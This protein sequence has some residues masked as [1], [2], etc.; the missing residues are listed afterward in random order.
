MELTNEQL[1][2]RLQAVRQ[3]PPE[4]VPADDIQLELLEDER[5]KCRSLHQFMQR[6]WHVVEPGKPFIDGWHVGAICEH[7]E[8]VTVGQIRRLVINV[9]PRSSKSSAT[10]VF[11]PG[12]VWT[13]TPSLQWLCVSHSERLATDHTRKM[14]YLVK[15]EWYQERWPLGFATDQM[16]KSFF[17]NDLNGHRI[18]AGMTGHITGLGGDILLLDDPHDRDEAFSETKR[19]RARLEYREKLSTRLNNPETGA[20]VA[21]GQRLHMEDLFQYLIEI[22]FTLLC[23]PMR[24]EE[25][26]PFISTSGWVDPRKQDGELMCPDRFPDSYV[27]EMETKVL[28]K[29]GYAGQYQQR[30]SPR[31]GG[32]FQR[33]WF[34]IVDASPAVAHRVRFWDK[35]ATQG[36][37]NYT[38]GLLMSYANGVF[39]VEDVQR[40]Q[41]RPDGRHQLM[42]QTAQVDHQRDPETRQVIE[43]EGGS[44][45]KDAALFE[46]RLLAGFLVYTKKPTGSKEVRAN[47]VASQAEAGNVKLVKAAWNEDFLGELEHFPAGKFN[48]IVDA[49]SGAFHELAAVDDYD[50]G[51]LLMSTPETFSRE[52]LTEGQIDELPP[53]IADLYRSAQRLYGRELDD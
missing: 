24:Y 46:I 30:P 6:S 17:R 1:A 16:L 33:E 50:P 28:G 20:I 8:A 4:L 47:P 51:Q 52:P 5:E 43:E 9:P 36:A 40:A 12:W 39:Y 25:D 32:M 37:G 18:A 10:S 48:D 49:C 22:G 35:A 26:H 38:C 27:E 19:D 2:L 14:R 23:I 31:G 11:W 44:A 42:K 7:L 53:Q 21:I 41:V 13:R 3:L 34:E 45:G 29:F 15:S